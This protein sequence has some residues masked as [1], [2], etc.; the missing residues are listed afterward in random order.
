M[1]AFEMYLLNKAGVAQTEVARR[2]GISKSK[3]NRDIMDARASRNGQIVELS[4]KNVEV[5]TIANRTGCSAS[6]VK[7]VRSQAR[8]AGAL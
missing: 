2:V 3:A 1:N 8:A 4:A 7:R 5:S 6:T